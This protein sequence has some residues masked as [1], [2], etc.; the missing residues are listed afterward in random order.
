[1]VA[2]ADIKDMAAAADRRDNK[3]FAAIVD[4]LMPHFD[5]RAWDVF[6][7][8]VSLVDEDHAALCRR[9]ADAF[10]RANEEGIFRRVSF[11]SAFRAEMILNRL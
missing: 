11:G 4:R 7:Q 2:W 10:A 9:H 3:A 6:L 5:V 1:M 8:C